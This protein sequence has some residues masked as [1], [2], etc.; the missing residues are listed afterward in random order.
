MLKSV[1]VYWWYHRW[2]SSW[3]WSQYRCIDEITGD[4]VL[5]VVASTGVLMWS[6]VSEFLMLKPVQVLSRAHLYEQ[7]CS[8]DADVVLFAVSN[9][10][11]GGPFSVFKVLLYDIIWTELKRDVTGIISP[12]ATANISSIFASILVLFIWHLPSKIFNISLYVYR[13]KYFRKTR[14]NLH[15]ICHRKKL[16]WWCTM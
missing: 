11:S 4:W 9:T 13:R 1:Q 16:I 15:Q 5:D 10:H 6:Q 12:T 7:S 3:C 8:D 2:V 14:K